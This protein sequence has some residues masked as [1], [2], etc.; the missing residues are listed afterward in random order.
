MTRASSARVGLVALI[1]IV[2][3][4]PEVGERL[5]QKILDALACYERE[6]L[7]EVARSTAYDAPPPS[8]PATGPPVTPLERWTQRTGMLRDAAAASWDA[9]QHSRRW[10]G[11]SDAE[12]ADRLR[13]VADQ[14]ALVKMGLL[15]HERP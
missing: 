1:T 12:I 4:V 13:G 7:K 15:R 14:A 5:A 9:Y 11:L 6:L 3:D 2:A 8:P 10:I